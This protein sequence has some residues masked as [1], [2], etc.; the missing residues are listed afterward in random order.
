MKYKEMSCAHTIASRLLD[1][2][3]VNEISERN[4]NL[5]ITA[6]IIQIIKVQLL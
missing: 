5:R 3:L 1:V 4:Q 6:T 2:C